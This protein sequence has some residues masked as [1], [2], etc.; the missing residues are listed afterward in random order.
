MPNFG[1]NMG[2]G[3]MENLFFSLP[4]GTEEAF[5]AAPAGFNRTLMGGGKLPGMPNYGR[6]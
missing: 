6:R 4:Q 1:G 2:G 3:P 5:G